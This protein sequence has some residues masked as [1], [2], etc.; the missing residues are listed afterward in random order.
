MWCKHTLWWR[1]S[2]L[3]YSCLG[4]LKHSQALYSGRP[5]VALDHEHINRGM[6]ISL[7][8]REDKPQFLTH[9][10]R[11]QREH[12]N[13]PLEDPAGKSSAFHELADLV[14][15][16]SSEATS[17]EQL[18]HAFASRLDGF[19]IYLFTSLLQAFAQ[20]GNDRCSVQY[21]NCA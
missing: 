18:P 17:P 14:R 15:R 6:E 7:Y 8:P 2:Q 11:L 16:S 13:F 5:D 20:G 3:A 4:I 19:S 21:S 1:T 12:K 9:M 10:L